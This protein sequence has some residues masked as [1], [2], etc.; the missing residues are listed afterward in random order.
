MQCLAQSL[1]SDCFGI[2]CKYY[3]N[4]VTAAPCS[5]YHTKVWTNEDNDLLYIDITKYCIISNI[6]IYS[7]KKLWIVQLS[8]YAY[9]RIY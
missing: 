3:S 1:V 9:S 4:L 7:A 6:I 8:T 5:F 2:V